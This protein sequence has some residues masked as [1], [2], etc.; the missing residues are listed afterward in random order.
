MKDLSEVEGYEFL[1]GAGTDPK[2]VLIAFGLDEAGELYYTGI[3]P[4]NGETEIYKIVS[5][6]EIPGDADFDGDVDLDDFDILAE[7]MYLN[8]TG[9]SSQGD[10]NKDGYVDIGDFSI[11]ALNI[12]QYPDAE[13]SLPGVPEPATAVFLALS[14]I[15]VKRWRRPG[16]LS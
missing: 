5:F 16:A 11:L 1:I 2:L 13:E 6:T 3:N 15:A 10:F 4:V 14:L 8:V 9:G 12:G 7:N